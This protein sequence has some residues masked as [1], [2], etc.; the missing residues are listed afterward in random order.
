MVDD[1]IPK[2]VDDLISMAQQSV[3]QVIGVKPD[4][5]PETLPLV[6]QYLRQ[7]DPDTREEVLD[8]ILTAVGCYFGEVV[9]RKLHGRWVVK[10]DGPFSWRIELIN[11]F[12]HFRPVG[13]AGEVFYRGENDLY[14]GSFATLDELRDSLAEILGEASPLTEDEYYSLSCRIDVLQLAADWLVGRSLVKGKKPPSYSSMD[15]SVRLDFDDL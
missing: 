2:E 4:L 15:Y 7:V 1:P 10:E 11:C 13:M 5:T 14:D 8:L 9:R 12:L 6:D 3:A